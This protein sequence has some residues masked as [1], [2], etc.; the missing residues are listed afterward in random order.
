[1]ESKS[2]FAFFSCLLLLFSAC[3]RD[4]IPQRIVLPDKPLVIL[5]DN[6]VHCG[7]DAD[8]YAQVAGLRNAVAGSDTAYCLLV[9][10]GDYLQGGVMGTLSKGEGLVDII[11]S[12]RYDALCLGNHEFDYK[13]PR[14][15]ELIGML[16]TSVTC[17]NLTKIGVDSPEFASYVMVTL[18]N[19]ESK[20]A[21]VGVITPDV[22]TSESF[23]FKDE[24]GNIGYS[25]NTDKIADMVQASVDKARMEGAAYVI[26][27]SH[28]GETS[29][30]MSSRQ[31]I[32]KTNGID[33]VL[34]GHT[35][36]VI[37]TEMVEN[38][39]GKKIILSQ[40]GTKF[41]NLGNLHISKD[42]VLTNGLIP[43]ADIQ[44]CDNNVLLVVDS[45]QSSISGITSQVLGTSD[46]TLTIYDEKGNRI[47]RKRET[48]ASNFV[49]DALRFV[50]ES[51]VGI[52]NGGSV[53]TDVPA[54]DV[55]YQNLI[56]LSPFGNDVITA[57]VIGRDILN[58]LNEGTEGAQN[59]KEC[60]LFPCVSGMKYVIEMQGDTRVFPEKIQILDPET[61][62]YELLDLDRSYSVG[63]TSY[64]FES[65][66]CLSGYEIV[67]S[68]KANDYEALNIYMT[69]GL[70][71]HIGEEYQATQGRITF[72]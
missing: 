41:A 42:G 1:M 46:Y 3:N 29:S 17:C 70:Q 56:D 65:L 16:N 7:N 27:L 60:S 64:F 4:N 2:F 5:Y 15:L 55:T 45:V 30:Q 31:L 10:A 37:E 39:D 47:V 67:E 9:S 12:C 8:G 35:H 69:D 58:I 14:L 66:K 33:A 20:I 50:G 44:N 22:I 72:E 57:R 19:K 59:D 43:I 38:R 62:Q 23:A 48:N 18:P 6:D 36:S 26:V 53:R 49:A 13:Y 40:T 54:G 25:A 71:G 51:E 61:G 11:N 63:S 24:D 34:D 28:L 21:F 68:G 52:T 32:S